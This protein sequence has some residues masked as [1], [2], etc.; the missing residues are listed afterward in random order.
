MRL[1][2]VGGVPLVR[3]GL[4]LQLCDRG[5]PAAAESATLLPPPDADVVLVLG[6]RAEGPAAVADALVLAA[7]APTL[8]LTDAPARWR[9]T[10]RSLRAA[11]RGRAP[12]VEVLPLAASLTEVVAWVGRV[13][14]R[15]TAAPALTGTERDVWRLLAQGLSNS[16][17]AARLSLSPRTVE[18]HVSHVFTKLGLTRDDGLNARV[19]AARTWAAQA[20]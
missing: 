1:A 7:S 9:A 19:A 17:I 5:L 4:A 10:L 2:I 18:C 13:A 3:H 12:Q 20:G 6:L 11:R 16:G 8:V 15:A 14:P